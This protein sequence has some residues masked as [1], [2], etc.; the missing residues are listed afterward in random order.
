M[1]RVW[2]FRSELFDFNCGHFGISHFV[3]T[4]RNRLDVL[5]SK[6]GL[7]HLNG[8]RVTRHDEVL[9]SFFSV[10]QIYFRPNP[11]SLHG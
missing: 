5:V 1:T 6:R 4:F 9:R 8:E 3:F 10:V 2:S 11:S 7:A